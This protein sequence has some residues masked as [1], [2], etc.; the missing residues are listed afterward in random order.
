MPFDSCNQN[1]DHRREVQEENNRYQKDCDIA[2]LP[3][4]IA[5][6]QRGFEKSQQGVYNESC[7]YL[8]DELQKVELPL[9]MWHHF[10]DVNNVGCLY[11]QEYE[12]ELFLFCLEVEH[13]KDDYNGSPQNKEDIV[14]EAYISVAIIAFCVSISLYSLVH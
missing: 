13:Q 4:Q 1:V 9:D 8:V 11:C 12:E 2:E 14:E 3:L 7:N 5:V 6:K 10:K